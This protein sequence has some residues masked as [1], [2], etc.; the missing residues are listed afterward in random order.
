MVIVPIEEV[1]Q[2]LDFCSQRVSK[3]IWEEYYKEDSPFR[4]SSL[5]TSDQFEVILALI[6][7]YSSSLILEFYEHISTANLPES[8]N[9]PEPQAA[10]DAED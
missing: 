8:S 2:E 7:M 3:S 5:F 1:E 4:F 6:G 9:S 10:S